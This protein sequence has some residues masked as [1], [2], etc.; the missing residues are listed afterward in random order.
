MK[1]QTLVP[2]VVTMG[3]FLV[4]VFSGEAASQ[5]F[6]P[7]PISADIRQ[8]L[9]FPQRGDLDAGKDLAKSTC[10][11][12]HGG[13][14]IS[15]NEELPH[16]AG[17]RA[18]YLYNELLAYKNGGRTNAVMGEAV[19]YLNDQALVQAAAYYAS[20]Q[21]P[22]VSPLK[23][24]EAGKIERDP[25][26]EGK[27]ATAACAGCHGPDGNASIPGMPS[28][29]GQ[30]PEYLVAA[31]KAYK[32]VG[33]TDATMKAL[34]AS[35]SDADIPKIALYYALQ[36]PKRTAT[37]AAGNAAAG[38]A[39]AAACAGCHGTDGNS[40]DPKTPSLAGRDAQYLAMAVKSYSTGK[41]D[42]STMKS[43]ADPLSKADIDNVSAFYAAQ[44]PKAPVVRKPLTAAAWALRCDRCHGIDGNSTDPSIPVLAGQHE[45]YLVKALNEYRTKARTSPAMLAMSQAL[46]ETDADNLAA[47]YA[48]KQP[49]AIVF[50]KVPCK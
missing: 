23:A 25:V 28:L 10:A 9:L 44:K 33:R 11:R 5:A 4:A 47:Y 13:Q 34:V 12:C 41:R 6:N 7:K 14:G 30:H 1:G 42:N 3:A 32:G 15:A 18:E 39:A 40:A 49:K 36:A 21:P 37:P 16:L 43:I 20:L 8:Q 19:K 26:A 31:I 38:E 46:S 27:A 48:H 22:K 45:R 50:V 35:L 24:G 2:L 17:Q 29:A